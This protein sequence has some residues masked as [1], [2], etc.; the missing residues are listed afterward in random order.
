MASAERR[1]S[2]PASAIPPYC[3]N[4]DCTHR[5]CPP[6]GCSR[7]CPEIFWCPQCTRSWCD[8]CWEGVDPHLPIEVEV[9]GMK[10]HNKV[11][12]EHVEDFKEILQNKW[13]SREE[14]PA[15]RVLMARREQENLAGDLMASATQPKALQQS[16]PVPPLSPSP[17]S[18]I[19]PLGL[20]GNPTVS[21]RPPFFYST[22][23]NPALQRGQTVPPCA[24]PPTGPAQLLTSQQIQPMPTWLQTQ[25]Q[26]LHT[27]KRMLTTSEEQDN[28]PKRHHPGIPG[29][30]MSPSD[31]L[32]LLDLQRSR[33]EQVAHEVNTKLTQFQFTGKIPSSTGQTDQD[34]PGQGEIVQAGPSKST[35]D[36]QDLPGKDT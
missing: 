20:Q 26:E 22:T 4:I 30:S 9:P 17:P 16:Q 5:F 11:K 15:M 31:Y 1:S 34:M 18:T 35:T 7:L 13:K 29:P 14:H 24:Q 32:R 25:M 28:V 23:Q 19:Q 6:E 12:L 8:N 27:R 2:Q 10:P 21:L 36:T 33:S 3:Q